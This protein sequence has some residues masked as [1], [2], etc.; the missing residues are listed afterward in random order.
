MPAER[1][2]TECV[3]LGGPAATAPAEGYE[4]PHGPW[5][6]TVVFIVVIRWHQEKWSPWPV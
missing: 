1:V 2:G 6:V 4:M 3:P 5:F